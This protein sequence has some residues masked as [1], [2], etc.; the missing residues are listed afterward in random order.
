MWAFVSRDGRTLLFNNALVGSRNL[1][2]MPLD[3]STKPRQITAIPG[4]AV[5][6]SSLSPDGTHVV[7]VSST[8]V[9]RMCGSR[10]STGPT[11]GS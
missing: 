2:T 6:H 9:T 1:W 5:M 10:T 7:F 3:A 11:C 4:D 8:T